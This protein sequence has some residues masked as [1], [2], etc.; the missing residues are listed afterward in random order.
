VY[1]DSRPPDLT[2]YAMSKAAGEILCA[3]LQRQ[4][5]GLRVIVRRLPRLPTDQTSSLVPME[6]GDPLRV[7]LPIIRDMQQSAASE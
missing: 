6:T 5:R 2:E 1:V 3:D 4:L 7:M